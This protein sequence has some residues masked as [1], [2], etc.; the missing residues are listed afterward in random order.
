MTK[1]ATRFLAQ[2]TPRHA[3]Y[4]ITWYSFAG[5]YAEE[6]ISSLPETLSCLGW[7]MK[8]LVED[9]SK[10]EGSG[11]RQALTTINLRQTGAPDQSFQRIAYAPAEFQ[12]KLHI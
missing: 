6:N 1:S 2:S 9:Q 5:A 12:R 7:L 11:G 3:C 8:L 10:A 4:G